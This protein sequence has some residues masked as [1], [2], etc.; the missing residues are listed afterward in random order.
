MKSIAFNCCSVGLAACIACTNPAFAE[1]RSVST[2]GRAVVAAELTLDQAKHNALSQ[3]RALAVEQAAGVT[4]SSVALL[5]DSMIVSDLVQTLA[6]G[7]IVR[8]N[9]TA[10]SGSWATETKSGELG[11]PVVEV[12]LDA[13]VDVRPKQFFRND[14][15]KVQLDKATYRDGETGNLQ[16]EA[17]E[18]LAI[19]VVNYTAK[20]SIV[21]IFPYTKGQANTVAKGGVLKLP[22]TAADGWDIVM[23]NYAGHERDAEAFIVLG[24]PSNAQTDGIA[25]E[26]LFVPGAEIPYATFFEQL[27]S[28]PLDWIA[29]QTVVYTVVRE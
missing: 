2:V 29:Q 1:T 9:A 23:H 15:L 26:K 21:P 19:L 10:W 8:E 18:D 5:Q 16:I 24:F 13:V 25:W 20:S 12:K 27:L 6:Y 4:V 17:K 22:T 7:F 28:L 3:A 14:L 11:Y